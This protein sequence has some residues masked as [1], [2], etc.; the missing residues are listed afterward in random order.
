MDIRSHNRAVW[1]VLGTQDCPWTRPV[2]TADIAAA[3]Q[4]RWQIYLTPA[5]PVPSTWLAP[6]ENRTL[7]CLA[8]G[9]G[10]Q[11]PILAAAGAR[12]TVLDFSHQQLARDQAVAA[13][14]GL[15][16]ET[17]HADMTDLSMFADKCFDVIVHPVANVYIPDVQAV[18]REA[19][20]V[21]RAGGKLL[22]GFMNPMLYIFD[23]DR[24][25]RSEYIVRHRLPYS[26]L[27][28]ISAEERQQLIDSGDA[29]QFSHTLEAQLA[30]QLAVGLHITGFYEDRRTEHPLAAYMPTHFATCAVKP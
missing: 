23:Q 3:R 22:A 9:G 20:R 17:V 7:L 18:W 1:D 19:A 28:S 12:V 4:G 13:R 26:E 29:L 16:L 2:T 15:P 27:T 14:D 24:L 11:G 6:V 25:A 30:G 8:S 5:T 21:L 10:Q